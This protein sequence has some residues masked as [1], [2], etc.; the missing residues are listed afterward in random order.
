MYP[1]GAFITIPGGSASYTCSTSGVSG[2]F[3]VSEQ[4]LVNDTLLEDLELDN[5]MV[6]AGQLRFFMITMGYNNTN[7]RCRANLT[8]GSIRTSR[9]GSLLLIQ[10]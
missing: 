3:I 2:D 4:W 5:I 6:V 10:G 7:I 9:G 1:S 8:S